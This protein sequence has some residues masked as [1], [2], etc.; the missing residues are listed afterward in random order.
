M[1]L[2]DIRA[3]YQLSVALAISH[4]ATIAPDDLIWCGR[5]TRVSWQ[6]AIVLGAV[7]GLLVEVINF[8]GRAIGWQTARRR[9]LEAGKRR[10]PSLSRHIDLPA[11]GLVALTR[12]AI[13]GS[14]ALV[15]HTQIMGPAAAIAVGAAG[16]AILAQ[17]GRIPSVQ[18]TVQSGGQHD[19]VVIPTTNE[20]Q[21]ESIISRQSDGVSQ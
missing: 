13:G 7:G 20:A 8:F 14:A 5:G 2:Y 18:E 11:D 1:M 19:R 17:L 12:L 4:S 3:N 15:L 9:A 6:I 16:P 10:L 21:T